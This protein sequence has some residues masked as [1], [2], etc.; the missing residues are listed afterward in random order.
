M[1]N[2]GLIRF[3]AWAFVLVC[4]Y[5]L[6]YT[7]VTS[8]VNRKARNAAEAYAESESTKQKAAALAN[9]D[10]LATQVK[11]DS[12]KTAYEAHYLD[13]MASEKV[14]LGST[15]RQCQGKEINLGLDLK[16]GMNVMLEVSIADVVRSKA[17]K[18]IQDNGLFENAMNAALERQKKETN[19]N[20]VDLFCEEFNRL[21]K[22][23]K[24]APYFTQLSDVKVLLRTRMFKVYLRPRQSQ[25]TI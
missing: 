24:L 17:N 13:S 23:A 22:N 14:Y 8:S 15:Y 21:D 11:L 5:Q 4:L 7:F 25:L 3:L 16:G 1:Q 10:A 6:S 19:K 2:K 20:F 18:G 9:N 12:L